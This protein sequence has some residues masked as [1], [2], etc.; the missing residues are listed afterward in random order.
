MVCPGAVYRLP[1]KKKEEE[2][3]K[4]RLSLETGGTLKARLL[5][6]P[7]RQT[8]RRDGVARDGEGKVS[9]RIGQTL[10]FEF[11]QVFFT[12][13]FPISIYSNI[14]NFRKMELYVYMEESSP[15]G[16][17][18][19]SNPFLKIPSSFLHLQFSISIYLILLILV[20]WNYI[21]IWRRVVQEG[22]EYGGIKSFPPNSSHLQF[23][24]SIY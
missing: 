5:L 20:R 15:R 10:S 19:V 11:R 21:Y 24:I 14:V 8:S 7:S 23:F 2:R 3:K 22:R 16:N 18:V 13:N 17:T 6:L 4:P 9:R 1:E 12:S